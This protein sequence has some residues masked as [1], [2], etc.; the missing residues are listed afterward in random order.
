[1]IENKLLHYETRA[2]FEQDKPNIANTSIAF[3]DEGR[4]IYTWGKEYNSSQVQEQIDDVTGEVEQIEREWQEALDEKVAQLT[5]LV[6]QKHADAVSRAR[7]DIQNAQNTIAEVSQTLGS[8]QESCSTKK[9]LE[10]VDGKITA[11]TNW[12]NLQEQSLTELSQQLDAIE[13]RIV[14]EGTYTNIVNNAITNYNHEVDLKIAQAKEEMSYANT[15]E[16][17]ET[18]V[19]RLMDAENG[20]L[21]DYATIVYL[22]QQIEGLAKTA[23]ISNIVEQTLNAKDPSWNTLV[24]RVATVEGTT[25]TLS[26]Q[27]TNLS[28]TVNGFSAITTQIQDH[29]TRIA[30]IESNVDD[31]ESKVTLAAVYKVVNEDVNKTIAAKI[32]AQA[33]AQGSNITLSA[34]KIN[35]SGDTTVLGNFVASKINATDITAKALNI[36][37]TSTGNSI[38]ADATNGLKFTDGTNG[39]STFTVNMNG[40][41]SIGYRT[42][43]E[44]VNGETVT[45]YEPAI[46]WDQN[47]NVQINSALIGGGGSEQTGPTYV[48]NPY[49]DQWIR[50]WKDTIDSWKGQITTWKSQLESDNNSRAYLTAAGIVFDNSAVLDPVTNSGSIV[51]VT[52]VSTQNGTVPAGVSH[53]AV[54][55]D[56]NGQH[57]YYLKNDGTGELAFGNIKWDKDGNL[58]IKNLTVEGNTFQS[59]QG[60]KVFKISKIQSCM[61]GVY[62]DYTISSSGVLL[63]QGRTYI[64]SVQD[65]AA[66]RNMVPGVNGI[67]APATTVQYLYEA[68][69]YPAS[70]GNYYN[71]TKSISIYPGQY[72]QLWSFIPQTTIIPPTYIG[73][74]GYYLDRWVYKCT[75]ASGIMTYLA[76]RSFEY[77][78]GNGGST[79]VMPSVT[80][81]AAY[82]DY[83]TYTDIDDARRWTD[84]IPINP[85]QRVFVDVH[86]KEIFSIPTEDTTTYPDGRKWLLEDGEN[87]EVQCEDYYIYGPFTE[88]GHDK[89]TA[90]DTEQEAQAAAN[91]YPTSIKPNVT[92]YTEGEGTPGYE[93]TLTD[94]ISGRTNI[95]TGS[96]VDLPFY[97]N[98]HIKF[99]RNP[100]SFY[101]NAPAPFV[102]NPR[103]SHTTELEQNYDYFAYSMHAITVDEHRFG[104]QTW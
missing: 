34:D 49:N 80:A 5:E 59:E 90:Y 61:D 19:G 75:T 32:F 85:A 97:G 45:T 72:R 102:P 4:T 48:Q 41:G 39:R 83:W 66:Y 36:T 74:T 6:T 101:D 77:P 23:D 43:T 21:K 46:S 68:I 9:E 96:I 55:G 86:W 26:T 15:D 57:G 31:D 28:A 42:V 1:M 54:G 56:L 91:E 37:N 99:K 92:D 81:S 17:T 11:I 29:E 24:S 3:I 12:Y 69:G 2:A 65:M 87:L 89:T 35:L 82:G 100:Y 94:S 73:E 63:K 44:E 30:Q 20:I 27:Y 71:T 95:R 51:A 93:S 40:S 16:M 88:F 33:N 98:G 47:G 7:A 8:L 70:A 38:T 50:D 10:A 76:Q 103:A 22:D 64:N 18:V 25:Q 60:H 62:M 67:I 58:T 53:T 78:D 104:W 13:G 52:S 14:T 84:P 79:E